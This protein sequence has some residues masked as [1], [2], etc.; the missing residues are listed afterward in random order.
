MKNVLFSLL[1]LAAALAPVRVLGQNASATWALGS[2]TAAATTGNVVA[3][4]QILSGGVPAR[5]GGRTPEERHAM[6]GNRGEKSIVS[7]PH[8]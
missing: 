3:A 5:I 1:L 4:S 6:P 8:C 7:S 2:G